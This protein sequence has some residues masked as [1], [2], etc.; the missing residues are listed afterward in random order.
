MVS[1]YGFQLKK[2]RYGVH[3]KKRLDLLRLTRNSNRNKIANYQENKL[4]ETINKSIQHVSYYKSH[5]SDKLEQDSVQAFDLLAKLP[6]LTKDNLRNFSNDIKADNISNVTVISTSGTSGTPL[7]VITTK[8]AIQINYAFFWNFLE[9]VGIN[10]GDRSVTFA[11]RNIIPPSQT[12]PPFWRKNWSM[13]NMLCSTYHLSKENIPYY[14]KAME[15]FNPRLIDSYPSA[16]YTIALYILENKIKHQVRP[17]AIVTSSE[18]LLEPQRKAIEE[19]FNCTV[20]DQY[21]SAEMC[22]FAAQC[23]NGSYH[24]HPEYGYLEVVDENGKKTSSGNIGNLL[25]TSLINP[26]MPLIRYQIGDSGILS[27]KKCACGWETQILQSIEGR[28]DDMI[29][30]PSGKKVGR[31]DPIFKGLSNIKE[32]QIEQDRPDRVVVKIVPLENF[33]KETTSEHLK[34]ELRNRL[35]DDIEV[36]FTYPKEIEKTK[37]GKFRSVIST[38]NKN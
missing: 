33:N 32:T 4:K 35:G 21:G 26:A 36:L 28:L 27:N 24:V 31:L 30:T 12:R 8:E 7:N 13:N 3:F 19:A 20:Y 18:T 38:F 5:Y 1:M 29:V 11:G 16:I 25:C 37:S 9:S 17:K 22:V 10:F 6:I 15:S 14:I 23:E 2:L 34:K